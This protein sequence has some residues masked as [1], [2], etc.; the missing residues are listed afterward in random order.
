MH[1]KFWSENL[2]GRHFFG[3]TG[4]NERILKW[5]RVEEDEEVKCF[6]TAQDISV[7][8]RHKISSCIIQT[9]LSTQASTV[10]RSKGL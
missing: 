7:I 2:K 5:V 4:V 1:A 9:V 10:I 8:K 3:E 6:H